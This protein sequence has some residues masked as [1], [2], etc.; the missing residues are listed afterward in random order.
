MSSQ[1]VLRKEKEH[2]IEQ[3]AV[4]KVIYSSSPLTFVLCTRRHRKSTYQ[5]YEHVSCLI[6][7]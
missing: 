5:Y 1:L 4:G 6:H 2:F 3:E 7:V